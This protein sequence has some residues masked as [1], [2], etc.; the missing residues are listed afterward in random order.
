M[1][2]GVD[3]TPP[4]GAPPYPMHPLAFLCLTLPSDLSSVPSILR[5]AGVIGVCIAIGLT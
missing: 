4:N 1:Q 5:A 3:I 2:L